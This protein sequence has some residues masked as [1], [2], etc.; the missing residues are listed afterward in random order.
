LKFVNESR[1]WVVGAKGIILFTDDGGRT[2]ERQNSSV[3]GHLY[4]IETRGKDIAIVVGENGVILRTSNAGQSWERIAADTR[5]TLVNVAF[6]N[7]HQGWI[8]GWNGTILR[9][10][11]GG[12]TWVEQESGTRSHL[13]GLSVI[14]KDVWVSGAEGMV[15]K[16]S[17]N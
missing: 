1:G 15:L 11:D 2:W 8:A 6:S 12:K 13:Y 4:H 14:K 3:G 9:S 5:E 10:S 7:N 17:G 16:Y